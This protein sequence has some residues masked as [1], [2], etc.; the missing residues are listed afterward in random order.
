MIATQKSKK[1]SEEILKK[2]KQE[3]STADIINIKDIQKNFLY[4]KDN[5][6][7]CYIKVET[8]NCKLL[9]DIELEMLINQLAVELS[10]IQQQ[11]FLYFTNRPANTNKLIE[12]QT[13]MY[14]QTTNF[15]KKEVLLNTINETYKISSTGEALEKQAYIVLF[16]NNTNDYAEDDLLKKS[17]DII[18]KLQNLKFSSRLLEEREIIQLANSYINS[19]FA[20]TEDSNY[21]NAIPMLNIGGG[22]L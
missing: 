9:S 20:Y 19:Q 2:K 14:E 13:N 16:E 5:K 21:L 17:N 18:H 12:D 8:R 6:I 1:V 22:I 3:L 4:S 15:K 7:F 10:T 11:F